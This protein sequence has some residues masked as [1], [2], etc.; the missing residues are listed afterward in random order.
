MEL[1][2]EITEAK[3]RDKEMFLHMGPS[4]P[5]MHGVI[6]LDLKLDG[7]KV[8]SSDVEIGYLHRCFEKMS[9]VVC[10][11]LVLPYT[12]RL[13]YNSPIINNVGYVLA[14][15]KLLQIQAPPRAQYL[16]VITSELSRI[17]DHLT[18]IGALA[19]D[20]GAFTVLFWFI[21]VR[22]FL[23][24]LIEDICGARLTTSYTRV[25]GVARDLPEGY[26]EKTRRALRELRDTMEKVEKLLN[27][28]RI[29]LDR[30]KGTGIFSKEDAISYSLT[31]P[32]LRAAGVE[33]DVRKAVPYCVYKDLDFDIPIG[34]VG[35]NYDRYLVRMEEMRQ[36]ARIVEQALVSIPEG[37]IIVDDPRVALPKKEEVYGT[38]EGLMNHFKI[39]ME[40][41]Q[42]PSGE[43]YQL[44]EGANG[45]LG[46]YVVSDGSGRPYRIRVRPP[47]F[48]GIAALPEMIQGSMIADIMPTF[49]NIN[50]IAGELDR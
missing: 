45:E 22:E 9:E 19:M 31:G 49:G 32:L 14:V 10:W 28:N 40:G 1:Q 42:V 33:Y 7:E 12:D 35:D 15:E 20:L 3:F 34:T 46:F 13:N 37:P 17:G 2:E 5:T 38:I 26:A 27:G 29:F 23:W 16:R 36:S 44:V 4:H 8:V 41:I 18:C 47:C 24:E 43:I 48:F 11:T 30:V 21:R 25:G 39:V 6:R 50:M